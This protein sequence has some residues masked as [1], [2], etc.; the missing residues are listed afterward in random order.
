MGSHNVACHLTL[1]NALTPVRQ[2][3]LLWRDGRLSWSWWLVTYWDGRNHLIAT[4]PGVELTTCWSSVQHPNHYASHVIDVLLGVFVSSCHTC[5]QTVGQR[6]CGTLHVAIRPQ[7]IITSWHRLLTVKTTHQHN[8]LSFDKGMYH[9]SSMF[10]CW[11]SQR[12]NEKNVKAEVSV[13]KGIWHLTSRVF[14][15]ST[16][17]DIHFCRAEFKPHQALFGQDVRPRPLHKFYDIPVQKITMNTVLQLYAVLLLS[18]NIWETAFWIICA[19][20]LSRKLLLR[21]PNMWSKRAMARYYL[22]VVIRTSIWIQDMIEGFCT[23][24]R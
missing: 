23:I 13:W 7:L 4:W 10:W 5:R 22:L 2:I 9:C 19:S 6:L 17:W 20:S 18:N 1:V 14:Y 16:L 3:Y 15:F 11:I 12:L 24:A 21:L 8:N